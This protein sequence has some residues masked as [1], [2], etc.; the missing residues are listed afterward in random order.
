MHSLVAALRKKLTIIPLDNSCSPMSWRPCVQQVVYILH[1]LSTEGCWQTIPLALPDC[2][3]ESVD[4]F[5]IDMKNIYIIFQ[6]RIF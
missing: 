2:I 3:G 1:C 5:D 4:Y 6:G